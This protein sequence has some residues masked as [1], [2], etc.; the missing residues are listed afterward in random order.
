L[1][2]GSAAGALVGLAKTGL[3]GV[4]ILVVPLM[5]MIFPARESVG[6]LLPMLIWADLFAVTYYRRHAQW[7][8]LRKVLPWLLAG[9]A[10][11]AVGLGAVPA[12]GFE[13]LLG[14]LVLVVVGLEVVRRRAGWGSMTGHPVFTAF[15]GIAAGFATTMGNLAGP[16]MN[17]SFLCYGLRKEAFMGTMAW[18]FLVVNLTKVPIF[19]WQGMITA[20]S[21][22]FDLWMI[23]AITLST[24]LGKWVLLRIPQ[25][26]FYRVV[27]ALAAAA[28]LKLM[29]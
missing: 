20:D 17:I 24:F 9:G 21:L 3:P 5:A 7:D 25:A 26:V 27:M 1:L 13:P 10:V 29:V 28:A 23:P 18:L 6:V 16:I 4:G 2:L 12:D 14:G 8:K 11:G 19:A 15:M 22:T